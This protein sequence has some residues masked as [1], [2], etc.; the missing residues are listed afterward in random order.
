MQLEARCAEAVS[1][2]W[3]YLEGELIRIRVVWALQDA[4]VAQE[5]LRSLVCLLAAFA[6]S[7][8]SSSARWPRNG[9]TPE[10]SGGAV[11]GSHCSREAPLWT[12]NL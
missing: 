8:M 6:L 5:E 10:L 11:G 7:K 4:I 12:K 3:L 2:L 1:F 9:R